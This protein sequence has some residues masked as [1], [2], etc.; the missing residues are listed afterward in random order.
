MEIILIFVSVTVI[1]VLTVA[2]LF[3]VGVLKVG[4]KKSS[5]TNPSKPTEKNPSCKPSSISP[6]PFKTGFV[7]NSP[8][9]SASVCYG[10][11]NAIRYPINLPFVNYGLPPIPDNCECLE[12]IKAP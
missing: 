7:E 10:N 5:T 2:V 3:L 8:Q 11:D 6:A 9:H 1:I 12:F 4:G